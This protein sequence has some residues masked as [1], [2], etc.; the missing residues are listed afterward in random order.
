M[1]ERRFGPP[2]EIAPEFIAAYQEEI[3]RIKAMNSEDRLDHYTPWHEFP[4]YAE[5][6]FVG[7]SFTGA[8]AASGQLDEDFKAAFAAELDRVRDTHPGERSSL[9]THWCDFPSLYSEKGDFKNVA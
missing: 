5:F 6:K 4:K 1:S 7:H 2:R 9:V 8:G 3:D